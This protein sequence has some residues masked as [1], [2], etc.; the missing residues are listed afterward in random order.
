[1][2][3]NDG[4]SARK[5]LCSPV[6]RLVSTQ[7]RCRPHADTHTHAHKEQI[8]SM[9]AR[10]TADVPA[11]R[12]VNGA[13]L[14]DVRAFVIQGDGT[15][16]YAP[17]TK[18]ALSE[19]KLLKDRL[20]GSHPTVVELGLPEMPRF[21]L[22][23]SATTKMREQLTVFLQRLLSQ[24]ETQNDPALRLF[25]GLPAAA[26]RPITG[27]PPIGTPPALPADRLHRACDRSDTKAAELLIVDA[28]CDVDALADGIQSRGA[29]VH[30]VP[31]QGHDQTRY[32]RLH[33]LRCWERPAEQD[34]VQAERGHHGPYACLLLYRRPG[35]AARRRVG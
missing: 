1:M 21:V 22:T 23:S 24:P 29:M 31:S 20:M 16:N 27:D 15:I 28:H 7:R 34:S 11:A 33:P 35:G 26:P 3:L 13:L 32:G 4:R 18:R 25:L 10:L 2:N 6:V 12:T 14:F 17:P 19:F 30:H 9:A 5:L 8:A